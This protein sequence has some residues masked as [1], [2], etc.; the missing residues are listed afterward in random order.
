M[1]YLTSDTPWQHSLTKAFLNIPYTPSKRSSRI[2]R[3]TF[4]HLE[5][6]GMTVTIDVHLMSQFRFILATEFK[7][8]VPSYTVKTV[9]RSKR[10]KISIKAVAGCEQKIMSVVMQFFESAEFGHFRKEV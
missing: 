9:D 6:I 3:H 2:H 5:Y 8:L 7:N 1:F 4:Q 10:V